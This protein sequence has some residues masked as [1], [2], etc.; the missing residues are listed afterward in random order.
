MTKIGVFDSGVGGLSVATAIKKAMPSLEVVHA[1]DR[2]NVP[3]GSKTPELLLGLV[4]PILQQL[5]DD[6]CEIIIIACNTVTT[7]LITQLRERLPVPLIGIEPM[8][9]SASEQT[10]S[11]II[12]VCATPTT[13]K[14]QRY[15][16]LKQT[17]ARDKTIIEPDCSQWSYMIEHNKVNDA[18][19][20]QQVD[21]MCVAGVDVIVL[22][23]THYHWIEEKI[24]TMAQNRAAVIQPEQATIRQLQY[25]LAA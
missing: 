23:C 6:G 9:K 7:T 19:I 1:N 3:Y 14:S 12:A 17:Y 25:L 5:V 24:R 22:G 4:L 13:L 20:Q 18:I 15:D 10:K 16:W 11:G 8:V 21:D 2:K